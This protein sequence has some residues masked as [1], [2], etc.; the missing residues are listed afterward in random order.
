MNVTLINQNQTDARYELSDDGICQTLTARCGTGGGHV[1][2]ILMFEGEKAGCLR[3]QEHGH[4]S[5]VCYGISRSAMKGGT[6]A[7]GMP[8]GNDIQPTI[9]SNG[10]CGAVCYGIESHANDSRVTQQE[11]D[12]PCQALTG[13]MGTLEG[14][15]PM[16]LETLSIGN[17]QLHQIGM[18]PVGRPLDCMHD[19]QAILQPAKP[20]RKYVLRRLIPLECIRL[21]GLPDWWCDGVNGSDSAIYKMCGNGLAIPC[22]YDVMRRIAKALG[23]EK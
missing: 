19:Q 10:A 4:Q 11:K 20:P 3:A 7:G 15:V 21:Q 13:K 17:G 6:N 2:M 8:I 23:G 16:I 14:G 12:E 22:A 5:V 18:E 9:T 1:P